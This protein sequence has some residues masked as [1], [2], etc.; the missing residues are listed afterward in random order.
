[1][2]D[3]VSQ[4]PSRGAAEREW[5]ALTHPQLV[6]R[7]R[8]ATASSWAHATITTV[9]PNEPLYVTDDNDPGNLASGDDWV[10]IAHAREQAAAKAAAIDRLAALGVAARTTIVSSAIGF[11]GIDDD[12]IRVDL[13]CGRVPADSSTRVSVRRAALDAATRR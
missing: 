12:D 6:R 11:D 13:I 2:A 8:V 7:F 4:R 9:G 5:T 3:E 1:M 10:V